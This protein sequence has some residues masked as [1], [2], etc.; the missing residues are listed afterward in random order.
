MSFFESEVM[1]R[2][3]W[4]AGREDGVEGGVSST[5]AGHDGGRTAGPG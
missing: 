4:R 1:S 5:T 2:E 3:S